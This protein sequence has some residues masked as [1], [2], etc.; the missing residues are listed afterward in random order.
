MPWLSADFE[1]DWVRVCQ[2]GAG[3]SRGTTWLPEV[4]DE[5]LVAFEQGDVSQPYVIGSLYNGRDPAY[6]GDRAVDGQGRAVMREFRTRTNNQITFFDGESKKGMLMRTG[7]KGYSLELNQSNTSVKLHSDGTLEI[8]GVTKVVLSSKGPLDIEADG[9]IS[10][11]SK[12]SVKLDGINVEVNATAQAKVSGNAGVDVS[13]SG[14]VS[15]GGAMVKL[16]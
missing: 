1:T 9:D 6:K 10:I 4:D 8:T 13:S 16:N 12:G 3:A 5:V 15:V 11:R 2:V 7:D 14:I